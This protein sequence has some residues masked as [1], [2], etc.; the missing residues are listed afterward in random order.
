VNQARP[1][2]PPWLTDRQIVPSL[3]LQMRLAAV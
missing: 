3:C 1:V 2:S